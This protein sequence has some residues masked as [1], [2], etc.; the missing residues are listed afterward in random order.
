MSRKQARILAPRWRSS[1]TIPLWF[2]R[3]ADPDLRVERTVGCASTHEPE[4]SSGHHV[5]LLEVVGDRFNGRH[6]NPK[7]SLT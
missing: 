7:F 4:D 1:R 6:T 2:A 3:I 5:V